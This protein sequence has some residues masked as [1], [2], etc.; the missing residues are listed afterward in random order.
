[1]ASAVLTARIPGHVDKD[2]CACLPKD[3]H[4]GPFKT[5]T[6]QR[7]H[8]HGTDLLVPVRLSTASASCVVCCDATAHTTG[9]QQPATAF[10]ELFR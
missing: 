10:Y 2:N 9:H 4:Y 8:A 1:M 7:S 6:R 5:S 3:R